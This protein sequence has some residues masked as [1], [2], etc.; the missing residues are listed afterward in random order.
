[1]Q[2]RSLFRVLVVS[3]L[4]AFGSWLL[5]QT[6]GPGQ[7]G[8]A[9][10]SA[11]QSLAPKQSSFGVDEAG[12]PPVRGSALP[13]VVDLRDVPPGVYDPNN[14]FDRWKRGEIDIEENDGLRSEA[15]LAAMRAAALK[16][17]TSDRVQNLVEEAEVTAVTPGVSFDSIDY[18][19]CC[20]GGG[21]VPPD[22]ELAAGP[23]HVIAV[24][25]V[26]FEIYD[27]N[28]NS[29]IGPTTFSSF[30]ASNPNCTGVFDP[31]VLYDEREDR[32][33]LG[34]DADGTHYCIAVSQTGDPTGAWNIY[35]FETGSASVF[36]DYPHAGVGNDAI[37]MG[38]NMFTSS[39]L[40]ARVWA[41]EK[42]AM[43]AG[44]AADFVMHQLATSEDTPQ[45]LNLHGWQQ[46]TWPIDGPHYFFTETNY[47]G[48]TYSVFKWEDPFGT[49]N[50]SKVGTV[51]LVN[52]TGVAAGM[53]LNVPQQSGGTL[54]ANDFRPQD[55][56]YR[57]GYAWSVQ[58]IAC[59]PGSGSVNCIRW[60]QLD[61]ATATV[62]DAGVYA[63]NSEYRFFGD[64]AVNHCDDMLVG[65]TKSSSSM[66]PGVYVAGRQ[67]SDAAGTLQSEVLLKAADVPYTAF[68]SSPHR[69]GD[70]T[71]MT[72][73]PD[74][75]TFWYLGEYSKNT[76]TTSGRWGNYIGSF[77]FDCTVETP[78]LELAP[79]TSGND[80]TL[81]WSHVG[82]N[83]FRYDVYRSTEP[84]SAGG[85]AEAV[86]LDQQAA[87]ATVGA[88]M[89]YTDTDAAL[90]PEAS[91]YYFIDGVDE[92]GGSVAFTDDRAGLTRFALEPGAP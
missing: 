87:P 13:V 40:D 20:G 4:I 28:G 50:L 25:N 46:G 60:V 45:P 86:L 51:N 10:N 37:Y 34:I 59:N 35:A 66:Y 48:A 11:L 29:L 56:E 23:D 47:N 44:E 5:V 74:G 88:V 67:S 85:D 42:A 71:E 41:F 90:L 68:D 89:S 36:F 72:I 64:L 30:M 26:A 7:E 75:I 73:A 24:V 77:R 81:F 8:L 91:Y 92:R 83:V 65:Y 53:P 78:D 1:M 54:Q 52:A 2:Y 43:Y 14:Q 31:N 21:N 61:P 6:T 69:F 76:G 84:Y 22:P 82:T 15:E 18:N 9:R 70:Y 38:G 27:K 62:V 3:M 17:P 57:N 19:E 32:Y 79:G 33:M 39:F 80:V 55:F 58:T 63:S 12:Q 16:L 49:N